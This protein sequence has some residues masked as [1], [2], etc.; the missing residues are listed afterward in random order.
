MS[1]ALGLVYFPNLLRYNNVLTYPYYCD[2]VPQYWFF[3]C[4]K[5]QLLAILLR[6]IT[7]V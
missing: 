5:M 2:K 4:N 1:F 3:V 6:I 7:L